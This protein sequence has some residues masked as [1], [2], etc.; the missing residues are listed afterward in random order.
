MKRN[1]LLLLVVLVTM[2][3]AVSFAHEDDLPFPIF[4]LNSHYE[5]LEF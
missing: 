2:T 4:Q 5:H 1:L 3:G